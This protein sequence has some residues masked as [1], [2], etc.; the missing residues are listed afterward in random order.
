MQEILRLKIAMWHY[1][2]NKTLANYR[3]SSELNTMRADV[4]CRSKSAPKQQREVVV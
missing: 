2:T 1:R 4:S 3:S